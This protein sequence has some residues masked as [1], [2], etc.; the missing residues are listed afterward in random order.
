MSKYDPLHAHLRRQTTA[1]YE[2][3][4]RDIERI[5]AALL[6]KSAE[7]P[8]WWGNETSPDTTHVQCKA[9][10]AAGYHAYL[11]KGQDRV[12]FQRTTR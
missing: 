7:R 1:V 6:P 5:L 12:R 4:F 9:W 2:M 3:S 8:E 11:H 10:L